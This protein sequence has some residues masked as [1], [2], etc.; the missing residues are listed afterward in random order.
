MKAMVLA[1]GKGTRIGHLDPATPKVLLPVGGIPMICHTLTWL[2]GHGIS[3]AAIN[4]HHLGTRVTDCVGD[5]SRFGI[6]VS[7]SHEET[8][9]GTAGG[10][11]KMS[12]FF[13]DTFVVVYGDMLTDF[14]LT[15]M[16]RFHK[17]KKAIAT[18]ALFEVSDPS[19]FGIVE[20]EADGRVIRFVEKP[21]PGTATG[22]LANGAVYV[23]EKSVLTYIPENSFC[24]FGHD[25]FPSLL[26]AN[27]PVYG[28]PLTESDYLIDIGTPGKYHQANEDMKAG[29][30]KKLPPVPIPAPHP[31]I[32]RRGTGN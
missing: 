7:Y 21:P 12:P 3:Q 14:D 11:K 19:S 6:A 16:I 26:A 24:D 30:L 31:T 13:D 9:L 1:A 22:R 10:V 32:S 17:A 20:I 28:Y 23:L 29:R 18:L 8:L 5:G 4:L 2:K 27:L 15:A 25:I